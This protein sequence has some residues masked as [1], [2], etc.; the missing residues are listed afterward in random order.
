[1][2]EYVRTCAYVYVCVCVRICVYVCVYV[3]VYMCMCVWA[4][5]KSCKFTKDIFQPLLK[6]LLLSNQWTG[7]HVVLYQ[8]LHYIVPKDDLYVPIPA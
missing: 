3:P 6:L 4:D 8:L 1:M 7:V 2:H 5:H